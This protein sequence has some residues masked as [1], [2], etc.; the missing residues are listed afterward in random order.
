VTPAI[1]MGMES[2]IIDSDTV[3]AFAGTSCRSQRQS[4]IITFSTVIPLAA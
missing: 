1:M 4:A 3:R 2:V